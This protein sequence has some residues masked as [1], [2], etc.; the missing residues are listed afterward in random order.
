M[1]VRHITVTHAR[2]AP[3]QWKSFT[4]VRPMGHARLGQP[5]KL[6]VWA[7]ERPQSP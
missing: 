5:E 7:L 3:S 4:A 6:N 2:P 1:P